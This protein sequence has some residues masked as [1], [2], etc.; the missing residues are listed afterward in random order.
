M[1]VFFETGDLIIVLRKDVNGNADILQYDISKITTPDPTTS[2][3]EYGPYSPSPYEKPAPNSFYL[4]T[5]NGQIFTTLTSNGVTSWNQTPIMTLTGKQGAAGKDGENAY[6]LAVDAGYIGTQS[7]WLASL[8]GPSGDDGTRVYFVYSVPTGS[9]SD[10]RG[11]VRPGDYAIVSLVGK[12]ESTSDTSKIG[13]TY[14]YKGAG[15][16]SGPLTI[17]LAT[18]GPEGPPPTIKSSNTIT[19]TEISTGVYEFDIKQQYLNLDAS[20]NINQVIDQGQ[21]IIAFGIK[22]T[23]TSEIFLGVNMVNNNNTLN[24]ISAGNTSVV[25]EDSTG[26]N[27]SLS[28]SGSSFD[29]GSITTNGTGLL[30]ISGLTC[31]SHITLNPL[32]SDPVSKNTAIYAY[33]TSSGNQLKFYDGRKYH[34]VLT[35]LDIL[36]LSDYPKLDAKN[37][38]TASMNTFVGDITVNDIKA[39]AITSDISTSYCSLFTNKKTNRYGVTGIF[40]YLY[41]SNIQFMDKSPPSDGSLAGRFLLYDQG[42]SSPITIPNTDGKYFI[43]FFSSSGN[44]SRKIIFNAFMS[45]GNYIQQLTIN[46]GIGDILILHTNQWVDDDNQAYY[47]ELHR[48]GFDPNSLTDIVNKFNSNGDYTGDISLS[49]VTLGGSPYSASSL[50]DLALKAMPQA[51]MTI[52]S[53]FELHSNDTSFFVDPT[54]NEIQAHSNDIL[55]SSKTTNVE[56]V[57][58]NVSI[59]VDSG[60]GHYVFGATS[61]STSNSIETDGGIKAAKNVVFSQNLK[62]L[63]FIQTSVAEGLTA[64]GTSISD[65]LSLS[66]VTNVIT[67]AVSNSGVMLPD[68]DIGVDIYVLNRSNN[69]FLI[70]PDTITSKIE[71]LGAGVGQP[72]SSGGS[73]R[74]RKT[75]TNQWRIL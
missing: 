28:P 7:Q 69:S 75:S 50:G 31:G 6:Q 42:D 65:A 32:A 47:Y 19:S 39:N 20:M 10:A 23:D 30:Q 34:R 33:G 74:L 45:S 72:I 9:I 73:A 64:T 62:V 68:I 48:S 29:S 3:W 55:L 63:G 58:D 56:I 38:F 21:N 40:K 15:V 49:K 53:I 36:D 16:W 24:F 12:P 43:S 37:N 26:K 66:A 57:S 41:G 51:G 70:Y 61:L 13:Q 22:N 14:V 11:P 52:S 5:S 35:D 1:A 18:T 59:S 17:S 4:N 44:G 54:K 71:S 67:T 46:L 8:S 25:I 2:I 27:V 60:K